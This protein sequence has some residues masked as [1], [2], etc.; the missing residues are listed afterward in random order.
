MILTI[1]LR[2]PRHRRLMI[3]ASVQ[4]EASKI[5]AGRASDN[6]AQ[7][8]MGWRRMQAAIRAVTE[9]GCLREH[10]SKNVQEAIPE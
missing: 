6:P 2:R 8:M 5:H 1:H 7:G 4:V 3:E 9:C 10:W